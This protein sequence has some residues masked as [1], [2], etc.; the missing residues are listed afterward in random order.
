LT[1]DYINVSKGASVSNIDLLTI[2]GRSIQYIIK[3]SDELKNIREDI[4]I[5]KREIES[6]RRN[7]GNVGFQYGRAVE[8]TVLFEDIDVQNIDINRFQHELILAFSHASG[9]KE[10]DIVL[11]NI[12]DNEHSTLCTVET[13]FTGSNGEKD[14]QDFVIKLNSG[15]IESFNDLKHFSSGNE[16]IYELRFEVTPIRSTNA[17]LD[18][19]NKKLSSPN[20]NF[21]KSQALVIGAYRIKSDTTSG[22]LFIQK[23]DETIGE[24]VGGTI[25]TD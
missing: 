25:V 9:R 16:F 21:Q 7:S 12:E 10:E 11:I 22:A 19:L 20:L 1:C 6:I 24:Y 3:E 18:V 23:Y 15:V 13:K 14:S 2:N 5:I 8:V 17:K 4:D